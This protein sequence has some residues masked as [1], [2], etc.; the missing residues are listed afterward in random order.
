MYGFGGR[1]LGQLAQMAI[2]AT[3]L[4]HSVA[5]QP[6]N[7][8]SIANQSVMVL[9]QLVFFDPCCSNRIPFSAN[10]TF[11]SKLTPSC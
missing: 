10:K 8:C 5:N 2:F 4:E 1:M 7:K 3:D 11:K 6:T 9:Y